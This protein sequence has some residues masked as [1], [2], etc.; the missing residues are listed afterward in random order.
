MRTHSTSPLHILLADDHALIREGLAVL[1][2]CQPDMCVVAHASD[3]LE[4]RDLYRRHRPDVTLMDVQMPG[5]TGIEA[6]HAICEEFPTAVI[7]MFTTDLDENV[8]ASALRAGAKTCLLKTDGLA[9]VLHAIRS[10]GEYA[11]S[12]GK[13][14]CPS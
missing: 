3:G 7:L 9:E 6:V 8:Q 5:M 13:A 11:T 12:E 1:L 10:F 4:A 2:G 14:L